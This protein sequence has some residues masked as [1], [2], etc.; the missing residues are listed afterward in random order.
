M[1]PPLSASASASTESVL[2]RGVTIG[3][4]VVL[5]LVGRGGMGEVYAAYD[6]ELDRKVALKLLRERPG[7]SGSQDSARARLQREAQAIAKLSHPNVVIVYDVGT[8]RDRVFIAMEFVDGQT[9]GYWINAQPRAWQ[10]VLRLF[11]AAGRG[12]VAA[13]EKDLVHRDFKPDNVMV[14]ADGQVRVMDFGLARVGG[15]R[16]PDTLL[17]APIGASA[18]EG[19]ADLVS[20]RALGGQVAQS[21]TADPAMDAQAPLDEKLTQT[22]TMLGT[23]AY[24]APEQFAEGRADARSDQFSFC[25]ALY[26]ALYGERPFAGET[27]FALTANVLQGIVRPPP[28]HTQVPPWIRKVL[29]RGL[30]VKPEQRWPSLN[31]L[32]GELEKNRAVA[33]RRGFSAGAAAKLAGIWEAPA[34]GRRAKTP[35]KVAV[36]E[37]FLATGKHYAETTFENVSRLLDRYA[38]EWTQM[39]TGACEATHV[40]REQSAEVLDLR[41][42]ALEE[43]RQGLRALCQAFRAA[44]AGVVENAV[45]ATNALPSIAR[46]ADIE[47][48]RAAVKPPHDP[49]VRAEVERLRG[50]LAEVR[51]LLRVGRF[52][53]G[54]KAVTALEAPVR[55]TGHAP[56]LAE[57]MLAIGTA[58]YEREE[59]RA[60]ARAYEDAL[61]TAELVRHDEVTAEA[62]TQLVGMMAAESR[63]ELG[64]VWA[65]LAETILRR[66]GGRERLW[67]WLLNNRG[68]LADLQGRPDEALGYARQAVAA[69]EK[70]MGPDSADVGVTIANM[71]LYFGELGDL[72]QAATTGERAVRIVSKALGPEHPRTALVITNHAETLTRLGRFAEAREASQRALVI[73]QRET[74]PAGI[75]ATAAMMAL[76]IANLDDGRLKEALPLLERAAANREAHDPDPARLAEAHFALARALWDG[77][78]DRAR[79]GALAQR[80]RVDYGRAVPSPHNRRALATLDAW[81]AARPLAA[82]SARLPA[83]DY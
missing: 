66:L 52:S 57:L 75:F 32:L 18:D 3:R 9:V 79:A 20:T 64:E 69:K 76:A 58:H 82:N 70:A 30:S 40:R 51:T 50:E 28:P 35:A 11:A 19:T 25:V 63:F 5:S 6:P 16:T 37:A 17:P 56:L 65:K 62:A 53:D 36:R 33:G 1:L 77:D 44:T 13:H 31:E 15:R 54:I 47:L 83:R 60:A 45:D 23:P 4:Y 24:M 34:K 12:L 48:L 22:G 42:A 46:C 61:W 71:A 29:L 26:E 72:P 59:F 73:F 55:Q 43:A 10:D 81:L 67:G 7:Q 2:A 80:A 14:S 74:E 39:Y 78:L 27:I 41:M 21:G 49:A 68:A 8:Y 38:L